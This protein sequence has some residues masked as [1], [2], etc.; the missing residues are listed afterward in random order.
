M[1]KFDEQGLI[2][3]IVQDFYTREVLMLAYMNQESIDITKSEGYTCF[4]SRSRKRLWRKG[5][6]SG[7]KQR[8][9]RMSL[10][11]DSD[12]MLIEVLQT[13]VACHTGAPSCFFNL[14]VEERAPFSMYALYDLLLDRKTTKKEGS[15]TTYLFDKGKEKILK[16]I[17]EEATEVIIGAMKN[18]KRETIYEIADV[19]YHIMVLMLEM[20]ITIDEIKDELASRH[21]IDNKIKQETPT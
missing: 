5:E 14:E 11:C 21:V 1:I 7:H 15:Y 12:T 3:A 4:Y 9:M 20:G 18:D 2:P 6:E 17:G 19:A 16:K 8:V 13:G 10:D